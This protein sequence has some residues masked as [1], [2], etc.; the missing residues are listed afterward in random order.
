VT[1][2]L[3]LA[4]LWYGLFSIPKSLRYSLS[5]IVGGSAIAILSGV[6]VI[7]LE[8]AVDEL[9][10]G[11]T[12]DV[13]VTLMALSAVAL[14]GACVFKYRLGPRRLMGRIALSGISGLF[15]G[16]LISQAQNLLAV[17]ALFLLFV[18]PVLVLF[19]L[20]RYRAA[21]RWSAWMRR[22]AFSSLAVYIGSMC[23]LMGSA[24]VL[25]NRG[26]FWVVNLPSGHW[27]HFPHPYDNYAGQLTKYLFLISLLLTLVC[28]VACLCIWLF[29]ILKVKTLPVA[30]PLGG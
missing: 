13:A 5:A 2:V 29:D 7:R 3:G 20:G 19:F 26:C 24:Q 18:P 27:L 23:V 28:S 1:F 6:T 16:L 17:E 12:G 9:E 15:V 14:V 11:I 22:T 10:P 4:I 8:P 21:S 30:K 25:T